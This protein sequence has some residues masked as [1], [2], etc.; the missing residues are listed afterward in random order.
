MT[1]KEVCERIWKIEKKYNLFNTKIQDVYFWKLIRFRVFIEIT[2]KIGIYG[3]A[4]AQLKESL[5]D[6]FLILPKLLFNTYFNS[7]HSRFS[8]RDILV[9]ESGRKQLIN[10]E[11]VDIYINDFINKSKEKKD[12]YEIVDKAHLR[13]HFNKADRRRSYSESLTIGILLKKA[14]KNLHLNQ[15][16]SEIIDNLNNEIISEFSVDLKLN[17]LI[18]K[19]LMEFILDK[20]LYIK[21]LKRRNVKEV[22]LVCSYGKEALISACKEL[23]IKVVEFQHGTMGKYHLGYSFPNN[24]SI[25][26]F[27]DE[28]HVFGQ[29][30]A[31]D[32]PLP[33]NQ[34]GF[35][36]QG[37]S[38]FKKQIEL[39]NSIKKVNNQIVVISQ[40]TIGKQ[41]S[42]IIYKL[43]KEHPQYNILYKLHP[44]EYN[45]WRND[46]PILNSAILLDN[47]QVIDNNSK[48]LYEYIY[49]SEFLVGVY[50]TVIF[51]A[52]AI[53]CNTILLDLAGIE[54]MEYLIK[55][56]IV[57]CVRNSEE[58]H[59]TITENNF[60]KI[61][62]TYFFDN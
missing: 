31:D 14:F 35:K 42:E 45:R 54:Y 36:V 57:K 52:L 12:N 25:P 41:L 2:N 11:Y 19:M 39:F 3:K 40:G 62:G 8:Q 28:I 32:T 50:S 5:I 20:N 38:Y 21:S 1:I 56:D 47:F 26:Y 55:R 15:R 59:N 49:Q 60:T 9:F 51:E 30:W 27:P 16:E 58:I 22:Y 53:G 29:F 43:A 4:H 33:L 61:D 7:V 24:S 17:K 23:N 37:F 44:G 18:E 6:R 48:N 46:Y 34:V 13:K 10:G